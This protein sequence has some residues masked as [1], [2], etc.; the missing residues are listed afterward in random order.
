MIKFGKSLR[1]TYNELAQL[2]PITWTIC[3]RNEE[4]V[5]VPQTGPFHCKDFFNDV[6]VKYRGH[7]M[8][9]YQMDFNEIKVN[10]EGLYVR[11]GSVNFPTF[12]KNLEKLLFPIVPDEMRPEFTKLKANRV[13]VFFP[14][15][16]FDS[17][18]YISL[19]TLLI[20]ICNYDAEFES[21]ED[22]MNKRAVHSKENGAFDIDMIRRGFKPA[23]CLTKYMYYYPPQAK[24]EWDEVQSFS[25]VPQSYLHNMG[26]RAWHH[27]LKTEGGL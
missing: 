3:F 14:R 19:A 15:P 24:K 22:A 13:L 7:N 25:S 9:I 27:A 23:E 18:Y 8:N 21:I 17:S 1:R 16:L 5:F 11:L 2:N 26:I 20:R 10:D 6:V 12:F 4:G